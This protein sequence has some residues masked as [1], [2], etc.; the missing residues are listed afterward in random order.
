MCKIVGSTLADVG[1][2]RI[3]FLSFKTY[4][5]FEI[6]M[7]IFVRNVYVY[8]SLHMYAFVRWGPLRWKVRI[9]QF[10]YANDGF[11]NP[12]NRETIPIE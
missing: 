3:L 12:N 9:R 5:E 4:A 10:L 8:T 1:E 2:W 6:F 11:T 7:D